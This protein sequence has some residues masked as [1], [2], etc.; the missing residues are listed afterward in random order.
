LLARRHGGLTVLC[1][2]GHRP[3]LPYTPR[4]IWCLSAATHLPLHLSRAAVTGNGR[5]ILL[6]VLVATCWV[7]GQKGGLVDHIGHTW[8]MVDR[9]AD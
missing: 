6:A 1:R 3:V 8:D 5:D 4:P 7:A 9:L 2:F